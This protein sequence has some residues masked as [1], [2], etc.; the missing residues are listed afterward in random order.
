MKKLIASVFF[1]LAL[2]GV[3]CFAQQP[4]APVQPKGV[5]V[6][7]FG[8]PL[9]SI[10][11]NLGSATAES[12]AKTVSGNI[13]MLRKDLLYKPE[14]LVISV[15]DGSPEITY[16]G[17]VL[18]AVTDKQAAVEGKTKDELAREYRD[19]IVSAVEQARSGFV[20]LLVLRQLGLAVVILGV[21]WLLVRYINVAYAHSRAFIWKKKNE[22]GETLNKILDVKKQ[23]RW[24]LALLNVLRVGLVALL[25]YVCF[26][27][28]LALFPETRWLSGKLIYFVWTPIHTVLSAIWG[29]LPNLFMI[30]VI[31]ACFRLASKLL[32]LV[33]DKIGAGSLKVQGFHPDWAMPTYHLVWVLLLVFTIIFIFP[34]LPRSDS[35]VFKGISV[36]LGVLLSLGS[37]SIINN[38]VSGFVITYMRPFKEGD[39]IKMGEN[40]GVVVEKSSLVTRLRTAKNEI[41]TI[42][43]SMMMTANTVNY[44][45]SA[46]HYGLILHAR[47]T[48]GYEIEWRKVHEL[49][50]TA[51]DK[52]S[53]ILKTPK[54]FVLQVSLD[55]FYVMYEINAYT[56]DASCM[57]CTYSELNQ[58]IQDVFNEAGVELLSPHVS[59][60][61]DG[62]LFAAP[63][64]YIKPGFEKTAPFYVSVEP[65]A[66]PR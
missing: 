50:M 22:T 2:A 58:N 62:S 30:V 23:A 63:K 53:G 11:G 12:R 32:R 60:V 18:L 61:R 54:P 43:N 26:L 17:R 56:K 46:E 40:C 48:V 66:G 34:L 38:I 15:E 8:Q 39:I 42:P 36:F 47:L 7:P 19:V 45:T 29:Y 52:T 6:A 57:G 16:Q 37:T 49:L 24:L 31:L 25:V 28:F 21:T 35:G 27:S 33:A 9:F 65:P 41:I 1:T 55:D 51:A 4:A 44:S 14:L 13:K 59:A 20:W 64:S 3:C 10:Y 5:E